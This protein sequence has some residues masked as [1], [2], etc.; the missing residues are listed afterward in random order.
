V[1]ENETMF[2]QWRAMFYTDED[3]S[4]S[5]GDGSNRSGEKQFEWNQQ[6]SYLADRHGSHLTVEETAITFQDQADP[7]LSRRH[8]KH[9]KYVVIGQKSGQNEVVFFS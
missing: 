7:R 5:P 1:E 4:D 9:Q 3:R 2:D 6:K 8:I